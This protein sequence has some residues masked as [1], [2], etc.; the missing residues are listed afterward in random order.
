MELTN[1]IEV[2]Q[3]F[4]DEVV[5]AYKQGI[6]QYDSIT[7][8]H[9]FLYDSVT[10]N[11]VSVNGKTMTVSINLAEYWKYVENGRKA[12]GDKWRG[13]RPPIEAI[14]NWIEWKPY[15]GTTSRGVSGYAALTPDL[16]D[17]SVPT[18][19]DGLAYAIATKIAKEGIEPKPIL[20]ESVEKTMVSF[21]KRLVE[22][23]AKDMGDNAAVLLGD[24]F[25]SEALV[26]TNEGWKGK[27]VT[28]VFV[29]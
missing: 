2:L 26:K 13:H 5:D 9:H 21:R 10:S 18:S 6:H 12:Y 25:S 3:Q 23:L 14:Q 11:P 27:T 22:A 28:D 17:I 19:T 1:T 20:K 29:F 15:Q 7:S 8:A 16:T 4:A 24:A